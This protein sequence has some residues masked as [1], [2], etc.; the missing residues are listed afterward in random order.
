M[1]ELPEVETTMQGIAPHIL[2]QQISQIIIRQPKL[3]WLIPKNIKQNE[4]E[5]ILEINRRGKYILITTSCDTLIIHLGMSGRMQIITKDKPAEKHDHFDIIFSNKKIL[6]YTDPRR[7]GALLTSSANATHKLL[8]DLGV[9]PL[10]KDFNAE[11]LKEQLQNKSTNIKTVIMN[12]KVV[13]GVGNIYA[14]EALH[15]AKINPTISAKKLSMLQVESLVK[16]IKFILQKAI[17]AGGTTLK[18]FRDSDGKP[19]YFIQKLQVYGREGLP[20]YQCKTAL[21]QIRIASRSTVFCPLC[22]SSLD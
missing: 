11:Y 3:R 18:D 13:V 2:K 14:C 21:F 22:Q 10:K 9:E 6:R 5:T 12:S 19:G 17:K 7:F 8:K 15:I 4:G 1:P 16:A 20:C